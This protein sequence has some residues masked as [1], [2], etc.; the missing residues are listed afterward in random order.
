ML[1]QSL[2]AEQKLT[3]IGHMQL[4]SVHGPQTHTIYLAAIAFWA[5]RVDQSGN[6][7]RLDQAERSL[8][9]HPD[10]FEPAGMSD[11]ANYDMILGF[12]V[13]KAFS[14]RFSSAEQS[15]EIRIQS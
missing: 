9:A 11:N 10:P 2:I 3:R 12:D 5:H 6:A 14:F 8:Y 4:A 15:F 13:L 7:S 1:T